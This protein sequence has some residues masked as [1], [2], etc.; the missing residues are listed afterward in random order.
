MGVVVNKRCCATCDYCAEKVSGERYCT[1]TPLS[2]ITNMYA[3]RHTVIPDDLVETYYCA[4]YC[5]DYF[6]K[7]SKPLMEQKGG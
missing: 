6:H 4:K 5:N 1:A 2:E 3:F 7:V